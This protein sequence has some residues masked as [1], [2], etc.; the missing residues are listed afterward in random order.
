MFL[1]KEPHRKGKMW[2]PIGL[3]GTYLV[4]FFP[5]GGE[6]WKLLFCRNFLKFCLVIIFEN[7]QEIIGKKWNFSFSIIVWEFSLWNLIA[8][9][10][11]ILQCTVKFFKD[12]W[13]ILFFFF[14]YFLLLKISNKSQYTC[15]WI[16]VFPDIVFCVCIHNRR[17]MLIRLDFSN[18]SKHMLQ[19]SNQSQ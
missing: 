16:Y 2:K 5:N 3:D 11:K 14:S 7:S 4:T 6:N 19:L 9:L 15:F 12:V 8:P 10:L 17:N 13:S 18:K 1:R